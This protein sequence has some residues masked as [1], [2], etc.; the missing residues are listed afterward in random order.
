MKNQSS[1]AKLLEEL[2]TL[3]RA[4]YTLLA[5]N[6][7]EEERLKECLLELMSREKHREK[8]L[9]FWSRTNQTT[10]GR[11]SAQHRQSPIIRP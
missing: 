2:D 6:T 7:Y 1:E 4:R 5:V 9:Y 11:C 3:I 10:F 8:P